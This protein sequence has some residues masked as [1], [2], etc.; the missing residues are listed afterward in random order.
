MKNQSIIALLLFLLL[1]TFVSQKKINFT[2]FNL[3]K[4]II[5][6]NLLIKEKDIQKLF[7]TVYGKNLIFLDNQEIEKALI[8]NSFIETFKIK[9]IYPNTL[10]IEIFE[11][12]PIAV[13]LN[14]KKKFYL[15]E[16]IELI[17]FI[18]LKNYQRLPYVFGNE[19]EFRIF[20]NNLKK[21]NF[22]FH[23]IKKYT[24]YNSQ[25]WDLETTNNKIIKLPPKDYI[26]NIDNYIKLIK[27]KEF[28]KYN[29]FD[30]RINNQL[31]LK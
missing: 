4:I 25:R 19:D 17:D 5:E 28:Q 6:N 3:E 13:L 7:E 26:K 9:K 23:L 11:K 15:S 12:K 20:Y 30:Y 24:L 31:I 18:E 14:K 21:I 2:H 27:K 29:V 22:P 10:K 1:T 16:K 8:Q